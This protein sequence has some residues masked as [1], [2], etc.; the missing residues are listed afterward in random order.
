MVSVGFVGWSPQR[1]SMSQTMTAM[2]ISVV[3][4][5]RISLVLLLM[6]GWLVSA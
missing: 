3:M 6:V 5:P 4:L 1:D 2:P